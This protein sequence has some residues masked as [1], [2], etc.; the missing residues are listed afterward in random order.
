[1]INIV[2]QLTIATS[3]VFLVACGGGGDSSTSSSSSSSSGG[4]SSLSLITASGSTITT[5]TSKLTSI[6]TACYASGGGYAKDTIS[7]V[8]SIYTYT[9]TDFSDAAC[10]TQSSTYNFTADLIVDQDIAISGWIDGQKNP[11]A[12]PP[13][14]AGYPTSPLP[15]T[16]QYTRINFTITSSTTSNV[17]VGMKSNFGFVIDDSI[18]NGVVLYRVDDQGRARASDPYTNIDTNGYITDDYWAMT[19]A[20]NALGTTVD[21]FYDTATTK[22]AIKVVYQVPG[23]ANIDIMDIILPFDFAVG[24]FKDG[25]GLN[26]TA[27]FQNISYSVLA[28]AG[29]FIDFTT[30]GNIGESIVGTYQIKVC[31][32]SGCNPASALPLAGEFKLTR[33]ANQ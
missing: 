23:S 8:D 4:T 11:L 21:A 9:N 29:N 25:D 31:K 2:T 14:R 5:D 30:V 32:V 16:P 10:T 33:G 24:N 28:D 20:D 1:M 15:A 17:T 6:S 26:M 13:G 22:S 18:T 3:L 7:V 12:T 19:Y 27:R